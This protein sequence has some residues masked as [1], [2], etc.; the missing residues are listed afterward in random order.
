MQGKTAVANLNDD[1]FNEK[2]YMAIELIGIILFWFW[3]SHNSDRI[4]KMIIKVT[5]PQ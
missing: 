3:S 5:F 4:L 2:T 1:H